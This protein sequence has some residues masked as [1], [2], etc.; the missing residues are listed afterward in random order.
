[1]RAV[2][3][4]NPSIEWQ[5]R[6]GAAVVDGLK[7][8]G[9]GARLTG[10]PTDADELVVVLGPHWA[11]QFHA[12]RRCIYIDR[13]YWGDPDA[14]SIHW[15]SCG[16]KV[17]DWSRTESR[18]HP[19][20]APLKQ[21]GRTVVLCDFGRFFDLPQATIRQHPA[22]M[23]PGESLSAC[24]ARHEIAVGGRST[25]LVDAAI[26]GLRVVTND[27]HSP[28][29][30]ISFQA[31]PDRERWI[32]ALAWHNWTIDEIERGEPWRVMGI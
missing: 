3:H 28:V 23:A 32:S 1:M 16:E 21:G 24:L 29:R 5:R 13:A 27:K 15:L 7:R 8:C 11:F 18:N 14:V 30:P 17:F 12:H 22:D 6:Y 25:A 26:A 9:H 4:A 20:L 10:T 31:E 2:V 19:E